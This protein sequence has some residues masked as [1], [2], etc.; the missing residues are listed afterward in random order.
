ML[1]RAAA[2]RFQGAAES[3][4]CRMERRLTAIASEIAGWSFTRPAYALLD[5]PSEMRAG[6]LFGQVGDRGEVMDHVAER[7]KLHEQDA[8][9]GHAAF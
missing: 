7:R 3:G 1:R 5:G 9:R 2:R 8:R 6:L 4:S